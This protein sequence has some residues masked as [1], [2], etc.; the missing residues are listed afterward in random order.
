MNTIPVI[1][2]TDDKQNAVR[3]GSLGTMRKKESK[4][5]ITQMNVSALKHSISQLSENI[6][7]IFQ[8]IKRVG[9]F[10]LKEI[11]LQAEITAEAGFA[12]VANAKAG[13]KGVFLLTFRDDRE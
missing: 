8:D 10:K 13:T 3:E 9:D 5:N 4:R 2:D 7:E 12:I 11:Q 1:I 6:S